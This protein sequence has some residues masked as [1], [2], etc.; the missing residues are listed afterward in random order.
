MTENP[1]PSSEDRPDSDTADIFRRQI[2]V[3]FYRLLNYFALF[4]FIILVNGGLLG[5]DFVLFSMVDWFLH[6]DIQK[7]PVLARW[8]DYVK[9]SLGF[10][11]S[12]AVV[13]H[14]ILSF[15][16][17]VRIDRMVSRELDKQ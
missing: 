11:V 10:L 1:S 8:F 15:I 2:R 6:K 9:I 12:V 16:T 14:G 13:I 17:Q 5:T 7:F 4:I 3:R